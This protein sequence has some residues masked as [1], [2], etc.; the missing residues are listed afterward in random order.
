M[1]QSPNHPPRLLHTAIQVQLVEYGLISGGA[2]SSQ[3]SDT[4]TEC[5][6]SETSSDLLQH[7]P[8]QEILPAQ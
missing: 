3:R 1:K 7:K 5:L 8:L 2:S 6:Q 4:A